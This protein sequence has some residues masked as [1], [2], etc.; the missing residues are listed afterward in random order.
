MNIKFNYDEKNPVDIR[1]LF[2]GN[3]D[4]KEDFKLMILDHI[5]L[6]TVTEIEGG[7]LVQPEDEDGE[8]VLTL[9][10]KVYYCL[11]RLVEDHKEN[12]AEFIKSKEQFP[13]YTP[14]I[15]GL[16]FKEIAEKLGLEFTQEDE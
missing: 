5:P 2:E 3:P 13:D 16:G 8:R 6:I 15:E 11:M 4:I 10:F 14:E 1:I 9:I 7:Y 12:F